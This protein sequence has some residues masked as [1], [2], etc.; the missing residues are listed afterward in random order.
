[1][2][3]LSAPGAVP[4]AMEDGEA[5]HRCKRAAPSDDAQLTSAKW[6]AVEVENKVKEEAHQDVVLQ[7]L[8][9]SKPT[10]NRIRQP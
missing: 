8:K 6:P 2:H 4:A 7:W 9:L 5:G 10:K 3:G 1:M